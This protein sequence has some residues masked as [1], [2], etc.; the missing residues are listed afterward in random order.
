MAFKDT[1]TVST[2]GAFFCFGTDVTFNGI[3]PIWVL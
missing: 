1:M 2:L 3:H